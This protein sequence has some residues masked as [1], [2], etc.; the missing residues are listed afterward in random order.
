MGKHKKSRVDKKIK[1]AMKKSQ[2]HEEDGWDKRH[3]TRS[4]QA[5]AV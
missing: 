3:D 4:G 5:R 2:G 1:K